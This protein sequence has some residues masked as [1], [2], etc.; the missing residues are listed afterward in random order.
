MSA[1]TTAALSGTTDKLSKSAGAA[2]VVAD[3]ERLVAIDD[4]DDFLEAA[5]ELVVQLTSARCGTLH[6]VESPEEV[7]CTVRIERPDSGIDSDLK[8]KIDAASAGTAL[9]GRAERQTLRSESGKFALLCVPLST[10]EMGA[11]SMALVMGPERAPYLEPTYG[12]LQ[13]MVSVMVQHGVRGELHATRTAFLQATLLVDLF[14]RASDARDLSEALTI[15]ATELQEWLGCDRLAI[16]VGAGS[17]LRVGAVSGFGRVER[18]SQGTAR[19]VSLMKEAQAAD[20]GIAWPMPIDESVGVLSA[21]DQGDLLARSSDGQVLAMP[22][23]PSKDEVRGAWVLFWK[24]REDLDAKKY[25]LVEAIH[26]HLISLTELLRKAMPSGTL[27]KVTRFLRA[28]SAMRKAAL[29][30]LPF[31]IVA[32]MLIPIP[33]R[34]GTTAQLTPVKSRQIAAP[35]SGVLESAKVR[36]GDTVEKGELLAI[37]DGKEIGWRLA[38]AIAK[39][40]VAAKRRD[41]ARSI[42]DIE[43]TQLAQHEFDALRVESELLAYQR[44]NLE[45]RSPL[46]GLVLSGNL[47]QSQ[48]VPVDTGQKLFVIASL[49]TLRLELSVPDEDV[50]W[51]EPGQKVLFRPES[52]AGRELEGVLEDVYPVS[53]MIDG[54]N[55][56]VCMTSLANSDGDLR[57]GMRGRAS[58]VGARKPLGW[59]IFH[60]PWNFIRLRF[61]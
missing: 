60:K 33:Y 11:T 9:S 41:Q 61:F 16:G 31:V 6:R 4:L 43:A 29:I 37:L 55:V 48:G 3:L 54:E 52:Q 23:I 21:S 38:E 24:H 30:A 20:S 28:A 1:L 13:M 46:S 50:H 18:R 27:G 8:K 45:I 36:P 59:V 35:F 14:T 25:E 12:I 51:V 5:I 56:F 57:P 44:D 53:E 19:L 7:A 15:V 26:P 39:R 34:I 32:A 49:G 42:G 58:I 47:E 17:Q 10:P 2:S 40:D 22:M